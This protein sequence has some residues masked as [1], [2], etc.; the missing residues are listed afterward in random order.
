LPPS[1]LPS[2]A[3]SRKPLTPETIET[4]YVSPLTDLW[5]EQQPRV[6]SLSTSAWGTAS[7]AIEI[8]ESGFRITLREG[9]ADR[10]VGKLGDGYTEEE[11]RRLCSGMF[12]ME[13]QLAIWLRTRLDI[14]LLHA[15]VLRSETNRLAEFADISMYWLGGRVKS[16]T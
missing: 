8:L 4:G 10:A 12:E 3:P 5:T 15:G 13:D 1:T 2:A 7:G 14:Q 16:W 9:F 6:E 11:Y